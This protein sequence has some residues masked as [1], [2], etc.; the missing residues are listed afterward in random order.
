M[1]LASWI[2]LWKIS[3]TYTIRIVYQI[4]RITILSPYSLCQTKLY[5]HDVQIDDGSD[6][7]PLRKPS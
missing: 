2:K 5:M 3:D 6:I 4:L 1:K 7:R